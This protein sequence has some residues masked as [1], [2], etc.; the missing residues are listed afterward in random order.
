MKNSKSNMKAY[1][2]EQEITLED[3]KEPR[4]PHSLSKELLTLVL[5]FFLRLREVE[6]QRIEFI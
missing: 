2:N 3:G 6:G 1:E 5:G 4:S